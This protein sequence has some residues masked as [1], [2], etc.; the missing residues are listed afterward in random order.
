MFLCAVCE[1]KLFSIGVCLATMLVGIPN[2]EGQV[3]DKQ[4]LLD[5]QTFWE[6]QDFDWFRANIPFF[7]S[8]DEAINTTYYY[9]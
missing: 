9:R 3:L 4:Q 5:R 2:A 6:N 8:P 1:L 7:D